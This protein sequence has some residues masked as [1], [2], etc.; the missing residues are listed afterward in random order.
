[1][2]IENSAR[3]TAMPIYH[4][5]SSHFTNTLLTLLLL[6]SLVS[7]F[8][9]TK[10]TK[11][12]NAKII[13]MIMLALSAASFAS[14]L[15]EYGDLKYS[16]TTQQSKQ[17]I[18]FTEHLFSF[19]FLECVRGSCFLFPLFLTHREIRERTTDGAMGI[20]FMLGIILIIFR[21]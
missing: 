7:S 16:A 21:L 18:Y 5:N 2:I 3:R 19:L 1:M 17:Q 12:I 14:M 10:P 6:V 20:S 13:C 4:I 9:K 8:E 15:V 11:I